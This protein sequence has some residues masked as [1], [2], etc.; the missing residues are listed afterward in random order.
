MGFMVRWTHTR[1][2]MVIY[3]L[4]NYKTSNI[5]GLQN[6]ASKSFSEWIPRVKKDVGGPVWS[7]VRCNQKKKIKTNLFK[8]VFIA[9]GEKYSFSNKYV[10][11]EGFKYML[12]IQKSPPPQGSAFL[13]PCV[14]IKTTLVKR[15]LK[16]HF[17]FTFPIVS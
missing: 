15:P 3:T 8:Y 17:A 7:V 14:L 2:M 11:T 10:F 6:K 4:S 9:E 16:I 13:Y 12:I 5:F 1:G